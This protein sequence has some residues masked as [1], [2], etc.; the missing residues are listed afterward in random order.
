MYSLLVTSS[1]GAWDKPDYIFDVTRYLEHTADDLRARLKPMTDQVVAE[2]LT[3]PTVFAYETGVDAPARI[4]WLKTIN[5][6]G[7]KLRITF[8]FDPTIAP[9]APDLLEAMSWDLD[10]DGEMSRTHWAVKDRDLL[11]LLRSNGLVS[12]GEAVKREYKFTRQTLLKA[13]TMLRTIGH[14]SFD[15]LV[16]ELGVEG[17][18]AGRDR[19]SLLA[20]ASALGAFVIEHAQEPT[21]EGEPLG[22]AVVR[23]A[24]STS[25]SNPLR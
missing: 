10:I 2:L 7:S 22:V 4:G 15:H 5:T 11:D 18:R 14:T 23:R 20:R 12:A 19:G 13:C 3:L 16:L 8:A 9:I 17:L 1:E 6:R 21:A 25:T 24:A